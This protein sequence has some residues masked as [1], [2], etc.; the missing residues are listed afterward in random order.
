MQV[1]I[2]N[3][4]LKQVSKESEEQMNKRKQ[5]NNEDVPQNLRLFQREVEACK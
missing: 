1:K 4:T 5:E 2:L 3:F